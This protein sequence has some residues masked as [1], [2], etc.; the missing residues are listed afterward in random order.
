MLNHLSKLSYKFSTNA[1]FIF[2]SI[3]GDLLL[4]QESF[5]KFSTIMAIEILIFNISDFFNIRYLL[6]KFS[7]DQK[8]F[9]LKKIFKFKLLLGIFTIALFS[10]IFFIYN[11]PWHYIIVLIIINYIQMLRLNVF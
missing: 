4:N 6:G 10:P 9:F 5:G 3:I 7:T 2:Y 8:D 1:I 11:L